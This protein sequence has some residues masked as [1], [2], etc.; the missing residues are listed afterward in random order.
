MSYFSPDAGIAF[1][2][3]TCGVRISRGEFVL[4]PTPPPDIDIP[5]WLASLDAIAA[6]HPGSLFLTHFGPV[7][8]VAAHIAELRE[9]LDLCVRL[10]RE[11]IARSTDATERESSFIAELRAAI[12][13]RVSPGD[14]QAYELAGRFDLNWKGLERYLRKKGE[15]GTV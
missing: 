15:A 2:G 14:L 11:A 9:H 13:R 12:A 6:W 3:D 8:N 5:R 1:V 10:A 7:E 4:P